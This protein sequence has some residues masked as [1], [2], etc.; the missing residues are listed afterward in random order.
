MLLYLQEY[1]IQEIL[2]QGILEM[3]QGGKTIRTAEKNKIKSIKQK[4]CEQITTG[5]TCKE[6]VWKMLHR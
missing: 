2:N 3:L 6:K 1:P 5:N 4:D